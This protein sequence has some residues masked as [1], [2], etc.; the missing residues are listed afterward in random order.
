MENSMKQFAVMA[1]MV[2]MM[3]TLG[4]GGGKKPALTPADQESDKKMYDTGIKS[5][6][7]DPER[8][9]LIFKQIMQLFPDS[10]YATKAKLSIADSYFKEKDAASMTMAIAEY[11]EY[12]NLFPYSPDALYAKFQIAMC[13]FTLLRKP[14]R[15]QTNSYAS[16]KAF[17]AFIQQYPDSPQA[18]DARKKIKQVRQ[19]LAEH[20]FKIGYYNYTLAAY[21]GAITRYKHVID[22]YPDYAKIDEVYFYM[23]LIFEKMNELDLALSFYQKITAE[24][25]KS[26]FFSRTLGHIKSVNAAKANQKPLPPPPVK[27]PEGDTTQH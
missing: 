2:L 6:K 12:V 1:L 5:I 8:A 11:Q 27:P 18:E 15:D 17:E 23:G 3:M 16:I 14:E 26:K 4:C 9:R 22:N 25:P 10:I 20:F 19:V 21:A 24:Y 13:Y 7:S